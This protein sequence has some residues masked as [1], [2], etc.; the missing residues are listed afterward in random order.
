MDHKPFEQCLWAFV[1]RDYP[2]VSAIAMNILR[3]GGVSLGI[4]QIFLIS[5]RRMGM[6]AAD[7]A[8]G[9]NLRELVGGPWESAL[10]DV[11]LGR[12]EL[13]SVIAEADDTLQRCQALC[14]AGMHLITT[15]DLKTGRQHLRECLDLDVTCM[16][17]QLALMDTDLLDEWSQAA[18]DVDAEVN[19][20]R[21]YYHALWSNGHH[22]QSIHIADVVL[23]LVVGWHGKFHPETGRSLNELAMAYAAIGDWQRAEPLLVPAV[24]MALVFDGMFSEAYATYLDNLA[25][26]KHAQGHR[27]VAE[28]MHRQALPSFARAV[29]TDHPSYATCLGNLALVCAELGKHTEAEQL[30]REAL[31]LRRRL[32]GTDD[33]RYIG[34]ADGLTNVYIAMGKLSAAEVR[35]TEIVEIVSRMKGADSLEYASRLKQLGYLYH[36]LGRH[37]DSA[38]RYHEALVIEHSKLDF[39]HPTAVDTAAQLALAQKLAGRFR[40]AMLGYQYVMSRQSG[41]DLAVTTHNFA[42]LHLDVGDT[43]SARRYAEEA[44]ELHRSV[45]LEDSVDH[46]MLLTGKAAV[47]S[48][49]GQHD[50]AE[51]TLRQAMDLIEQ[52]AG[53]DN[54]H[55]AHAC[56]GLAKCHMAQH[57]YDEADELLQTSL[58]LME[59]AVGHDAPAIA[60]TI[61]LRGAVQ[62]AKGRWEGAEKLLRH[63]V[64]LLGGDTSTE[65]KP[66]YIEL[67]RDLG[68]ALV[69]M[70][71]ERE[72]I[73][74]LLTA[75]RHQDDLVLGQSAVAGIS[76]LSVDQPVALL[77]ILG[78]PRFQST[79]LVS[80][81][82]EVVWRRKGIVAEADFIRRREEI[83][84]REHDGGDAQSKLAEVLQSIENGEIPQDIENVL[85][86]VLATYA[87]NLR[88]GMYPKIEGAHQEVYAHLMDGWPEQG[89]L[90]REEWLERLSEYAGTAGALMGNRDRLES[91]LR[92]LFPDGGW[93][94]EVLQRVTLEAV[95]SRLPEGSA[96]VEFL[97]VPT[98]DETAVRAKGESRW[99]PDRYYAF[100]LTPGRDDDVRLI[101]LGKAD[102]IDT[103][104]ILL[105]RYVSR[106][107][108]A[109]DIDLDKTAADDA[110]GATGKAAVELRK[111]L[112][113]PLQ[114]NDRTRLF[115]APDAQLYTLPLEIL[116]LDDARLVIDDHEITYLTTGRD[117]VPA[118]PTAPEPASPPVVVADPDYDLALNTTT[119][120]A[121][122]GGEPDGRRAAGLRFARLPGTRD[123]G[124]HVADLL[125][126]QAWLGTDAVEG[127]LKQQRSPVILHIAS[128]GYF[129]DDDQPKESSTRQ[130][131]RRA[132]SAFPAP[133]LNSG[134][135]LA[136]ANTWL[137][138]GHLP[139]E[140]EDGLLTAADLATMDLS[141][142]ELVVLS[143]CDTGRGLVAVGQGVY[144]LR[145]SVGIAGARTLVMSMWQVP[146]R[147]TQELMEDFYGRLKRGEPRGSA[148]R[149]AQLAMRARKPNPYY[150][151][152]FICQGDPGPMPAG[153]LSDIDR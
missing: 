131:D 147:E 41:A 36:Q 141:G 14:Y 124:Q 54:E 121:P 143:A 152:A 153:F 130:A 38:D 80:Q 77:N 87:R 98:L 23:A 64:E 96:L 60:S 3:T 73:N 20:L 134:L 115:L 78:Q 8:I 133:L 94:G 47:D 107:G 63:A 44:I 150:W 53:R 149:A 70:G 28:E 76:S 100:V 89:D 116:P 145:R 75:E 119:D 114:I 140:A 40:E 137:R 142:T 105:R 83:H 29:G 49:E 48:A 18:P 104:I 92:V 58:Q 129:L 106:G 51:T 15:G 26:A 6:S 65:Q 42:V 101:D 45:G 50:D 61:R 117:L 112:I 108:R 34:M 71:R 35:V 10:L 102:S 32:F 55:Y 69:G 135:A 136:G 113:D 4:A 62:L 72:A 91:E 125:G 103:N 37:S 19:R 57:R 7:D 1:R 111:T 120:P 81:L 31:D 126:V 67:L 86:D 93:L 122:P 13:A 52:K 5:M 2:A 79:G 99:G 90:S 74:V 68:S 22:E 33:L 110:A 148:F 27:E 66:L 39:D 21:G 46:A 56:T 109:R 25:Q 144:G 84:S 118:R 24:Q 127:P 151:G 132:F 17:T 16:E 9:Q 30:Y 82:L 95:R 88:Y 138:R 59:G 128:H 123:E 11:T 146:D 139:Q 43:R 12:R 97:C 85:E